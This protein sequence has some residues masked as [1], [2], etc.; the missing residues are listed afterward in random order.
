[1]A[2]YLAEAD[3][4]A[5]Q[6]AID[7]QVRERHLT[8]VRDM[9]QDEPGR[10]AF[11][12]NPV[13]FPGKPNVLRS[14]NHLEYPQIQSNG[15]SDMRVFAGWTEGYGQGN[16]I[17]TLVN[18]LDGVIRSKIRDSWH[19]LHSALYMSLRPM[20]GIVLSSLGDRSEMGHS[21]EGRPPFLDPVVTDYVNHLPPSA[22]ITIDAK[23]M[24]KEKRVLRE[25][26]RP[27][28]SD[29]LYERTKHPYSAPANY[30]TGGAVHALILKHV[31][32]EKLETL[33]FVD[34]DYAK[35][36]LREAFQEG[37]MGAFRQVLMLA[38]YTILQ[39]AFGIKTARPLQAL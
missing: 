9:A 25:A 37:G 13:E 8:R 39:T 6:M 10:N 35:R 21:L 29:E 34:I 33:G 2:D 12:R 26:S 5:P 15:V 27:F 23:G 7:D 31:T 1:L 38:Q 19:P 30:P 32:E 16:P 11:V 24:V 20:D 18:Q 22:K 14:I 3:H 17:L 4:T 28:I 36:L